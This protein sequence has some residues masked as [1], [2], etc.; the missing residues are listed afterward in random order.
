MV[1]YPATGGIVVV[2]EVIVASAEELQVARGET[3]CDQCNSTTKCYRHK[4]KKKTNNTRYF[5][6]FSTAFFTLP[7]FNNSSLALS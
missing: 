7:Y 6:E 1:I 2:A 3:I 5:E 4:I